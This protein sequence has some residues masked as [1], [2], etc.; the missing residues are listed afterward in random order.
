MDKK[1]SERFSG[2]RLTYIIF[3]NNNLASKR[4]HSLS[5]VK[6]QRVNTLQKIVSDLSKNY[7]ELNN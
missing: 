3:S 4:A 1:I 2:L 5:T 6:Y 7:K